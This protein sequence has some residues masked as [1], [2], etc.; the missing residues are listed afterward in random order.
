M[1]KRFSTVPERLWRELAPLLPPERPKLNGG[2][3]RVSDR[4]VLGGILYRLRTG[5]Q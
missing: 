2:R 1:D 4:A 5:C 3:P